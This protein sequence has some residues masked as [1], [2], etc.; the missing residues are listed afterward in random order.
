MG[1]NNTIS[2]ADRPNG[3]DFIIDSCRFIQT[4]VSKYHL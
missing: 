4:E 1:K 3:A 2:T